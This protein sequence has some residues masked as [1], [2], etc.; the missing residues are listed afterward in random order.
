M[1][2][3][4]NKPYSA[5]V[6]SQYSHTRYR[7]LQQAFRDDTQVLGYFVS[8]LVGDVVGI[9]GEDRILEDQ[10]PRTNGDFGITGLRPSSNFRCTHDGSGIGRENCEVIAHNQLRTYTGVD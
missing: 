10:S 1:P 8:I 5:V 4:P 2:V 6:D 9:D 3:D 7:V